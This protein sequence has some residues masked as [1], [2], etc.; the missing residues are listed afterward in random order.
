[1]GGGTTGSGSEHAAVPKKKMGSRTRNLLFGIQDA[2]VTTIG[3][4][5]GVSSAEVPRR[6]LARVVLI[7]V[8]VSSISMGIGSY[9]GERT[10]EGFEG[11]PDRAEMLLGA[12]IMS[13]SYFV[14][15]LILMI[16]IAFLSKTARVVA[17]SATIAAVLS[18]GA[19][20]YVASLTDFVDPWKNAAETTVL[21]LV[22]LAIG[23]LSGR[24]LRDP[25]KSAA[26]I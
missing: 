13:I 2:A 15:G 1:M 20:Y 12:V 24:A 4:L 21:V 5:A 19:G 6:Y 25:V 7:S 14:T 9:Q 11:S 18:F 10:A 8:V 23:Y 17:A 26:V 16:P 3:I 22:A